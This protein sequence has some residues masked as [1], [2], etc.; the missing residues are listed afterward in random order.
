M[1][2]FCF[3]AKPFRAPS[4]CSQGNSTVWAGKFCVDLVQTKLSLSFLGFGT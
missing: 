2:A 1:T 4:Q 3:K